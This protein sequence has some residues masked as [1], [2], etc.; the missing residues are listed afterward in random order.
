M[1]WADEKREAWLERAARLR[2]RSEAHAD[3]LW[4]RQE[5][6]CCSYCPTCATDLGVSL[7]EIATL[8]EAK[9]SKRLAV[10]AERK[11]EEDAY[12]ARYNACIDAARA[13]IEAHRVPIA[14]EFG[15]GVRNFRFEL[16]SECPSLPTQY[17]WEMYP[18]EVFVELSQVSTV[19]YLE[20]WFEWYPE[21]LWEIR[22]Y[23][24]GQ[25]PRR[26]FHTYTGS[27][28][29]VLRR[30]LPMVTGA[31]NHYNR[32]HPDPGVMTREEREQWYQGCTGGWTEEERNDFL[33]AC[34]QRAKARDPEG[35]AK[36]AAGRVD[37]SARFALQ[38]SR[39]Q[40]EEQD[41][42]EVE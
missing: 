25:G 21:G 36:R 28:E 24:W 14:D 6:P 29:E 8:W 23:L 26:L 12:Y 22:T 31:Q 40:R 34:C 1:P 18:N 27:L 10:E 5:P 37:D 38:W 11:A 39:W 42:E 20:E 4:F 3:M 17:R 2:F 35:W 30:A 15:P 32:K 13:Q 33:S 19:S 9:E 16:A 41:A 7:E